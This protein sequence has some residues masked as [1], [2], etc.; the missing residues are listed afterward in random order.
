MNVADWLMIIAVVIAPIAAVQV[1]K[2]LERGR[3]KRYRKIA[4]F[5]SLMATRSARV[6]LEHV[7]ALN[8][9]DIEFYEQHKIAFI[10]W[11]SKRDKSVREAWKAYHDH[12]NTQYDE[13]QFKA[14]CDKGDELF[15]DLLHAIACALNYDFDKVLLKR[16]V[17]SPIAHGN[18]EL[19][20][21]LIKGN[22]L[23]I[24]SGKKPLLVKPFTEGDNAQE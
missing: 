9:I 17:Y 16:G 2:L 14:W 10:P 24:V 21:Q 6:S 5:Q 13:D 11:Q 3:E 4:L 23:D 22:F 7:R 8:M 1:Q 15:T 20:Q 18:E 19:Y 12:L